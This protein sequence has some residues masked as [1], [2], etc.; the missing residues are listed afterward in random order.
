MGAQPG[1]REE[2]LEEDVMLKAAPGRQDGKWQSG[3]P[4]EEGMGKCP[5][6][7]LLLL[8]VTLNPSEP[9]AHG[10]MLSDRGRPLAHLMQCTAFPLLVL[11]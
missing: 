5:V 6:S 7:F 10:S 11:G 1:D 3:Q 9:L 2:F 8:L 4:Q